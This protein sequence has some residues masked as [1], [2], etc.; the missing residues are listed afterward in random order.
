MMVLAVRLEMILELLDALAEDC[1]LDFWRTGIGLVDSYF[2]TTC[3]LVSVASAML[4]SI[5]LVYS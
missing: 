3:S 5:L 2:A 1:Y 4:E